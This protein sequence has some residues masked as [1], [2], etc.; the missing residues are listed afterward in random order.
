MRRPEARGKR[1]PPRPGPP[2]GSFIGPRR[3]CWRVGGYRKRRKSAKSRGQWMDVSGGSRIGSRTTAAGGAAGG[4]ASSQQLHHVHQRRVLHFARAPPWILDP[5]K[6][7][8]TYPALLL[9][10]QLASLSISHPSQLVDLPA[11]QDEAR[12]WIDSAKAGCGGRLAPS[13]LGA[14]PAGAGGCLFGGPARTPGSR[15]GAACGRARVEPSGPARAC[16]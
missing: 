15:P 3:S 16:R 11:E 1:V 9:D 14:T 13:H 10:N 6:P 8:L 12:L 4:A 2:P 5:S 7:T